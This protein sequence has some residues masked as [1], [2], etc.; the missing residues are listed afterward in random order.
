[1]APTINF[2]EHTTTLV[3]LDRTSRR[4]NNRRVEGGVGWAGVGEDCKNCVR[5]TEHL[6]RRNKRCQ[7]TP[8]V[9]LVERECAESLSN[10]KW[11]GC[12]KHP[13]PK[14]NCYR[15]MVRWFGGTRAYR[16]IPV[17]HTGTILRNITVNIQPLHP[18]AKRV[19]L[20]DGCQCPARVS[21]IAR[22]VLYQGYRADPLS[23]NT[24]RKEEKKE[25]C[26]RVGGVV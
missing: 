6:Q 12:T 13:P 15:R 22:T 25:I 18:L 5:S 3:L 11:S 19:R 9:G 26:R 23:K 21:E 4:K 16:T 10:T 14:R 24:T 20:V 17:I 2:Q 1:M 8:Y 7:W